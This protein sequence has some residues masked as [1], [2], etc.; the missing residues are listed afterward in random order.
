M[1]KL[2]QM[3]LIAAMVLCL[4]VSGSAM[5]VKAEE[6]APQSAG[7]RL[8]EIL[9]RGKLIVATSPDYAPLEFIDSTKPV[10]SQIIGSDIE[11]AKY[12]ADQLG[13]ELEVI[14]MDF[15]AV[16]SS[17]SLG[18]ADMAISGFGWREDREVSF[19]LSH[20]FNKDGEAGCHG[21]LI[22][23]AD[24]DVY[25]TLDAFNGKKI[26]AQ[27]SSLQE[28]YTKDQIPEAIIEPVTGL[29]I[30]VMMLK[31][32]KVDALTTSCDQVNGFA[33]AN[34][35]LTKADAE[36]VIDFDALHDGNV[37]AVKKGEIELIERLNVIIDDINEQGLYEQW[38]HAAKV[39][40]K[41]L[42]I[43]FEGSD[44]IVLKEKGIVEV[45]AEN[46][47]IF[48]EG[49]WGT[50]K[51]AAI[52]VFFGTLLGSLFALMRIA[53]NPLLK[54]ISSAYIEILRGT[55]ILVQLYIFYFFIP[56]AFPA[57]NLSKYVC[58]VISLIINSSAYVA[59]IIRSG[60]QA[61]DRGQTEAAK[62]LG[63]SDQHTMTRIILPQAIK[64]ILP[65]LCNE[66]VT[67][68]KETSLASTLF[69]GELMYTKT[70]LQSTKFYTWQ[71]LF[72]I[73]IIYFI[74]TFV[75]SKFVKYLEKR[76]SVSD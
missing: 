19:E 22:N 12:I 62:S 20:G 73:A 29:D 17:V 67:M 25:T 9:Q 71:P 15:S 32:G 63:M 11:M 27:V 38:S 6:E 24:K 5:P 51:L 8:E 43:D 35:G 53:K 30:G 4:L 61:V 50:L 7:N 18:T 16:L 47:P 21:F 23:S 49:L 26:A 70:I 2:K 68:I 13:V 44:D 3:G 66:F 60:I 41:E 57:L 56:Q 58:V 55:P 31:T 65:A 36:F 37:L 14:S 46:Y 69:I 39:R 40:A 54:I 59:E 72:I 10:D 64:N 76:M 45:F 34:A 28:G 48:F 74:V 75:L 33:S 42:G 1:G 52:T